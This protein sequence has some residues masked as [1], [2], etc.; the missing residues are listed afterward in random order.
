MIWDPGRILLTRNESWSTFH[1]L[2][3]WLVLSGW[4]SVVFFFWGC[5]CLLLVLFVLPYLTFPLLTLGSTYDLKLKVQ[6]LP[7]SLWCAQQWA[8]KNVLLFGLVCLCFLFF[9]SVSG[10]VVCCLVPSSW[11]EDTMLYSFYPHCDSLQSS[12]PCSIF[13]VVAGSGVKATDYMLPFHRCKLFLAAMW[14]FRKASSLLQ[15]V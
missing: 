5:F 11:K 7:Q 3:F 4:F 8:K 12:D 15:I 6:W 1:C 14:R 13:A 2:T 10:S 9:L